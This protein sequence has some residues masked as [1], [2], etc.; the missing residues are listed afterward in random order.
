M[1]DNTTTEC[2][3]SPVSIAYTTTEFA[4]SPVLI[5]YTTKLKSNIREGFRTRECDYSVI[6]SLALSQFFKLNNF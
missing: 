6:M 2:A 3:I 1:Q 5:A 4:I